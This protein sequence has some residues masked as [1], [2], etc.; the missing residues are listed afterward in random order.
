MNNY[1]NHP[2]DRRT[3]GKFIDELFEPEA[4]PLRA[5]LFT[6]GGTIIGFIVLKMAAAKIQTETLLPLYCIVSIA[7]L[8]GV[9]IYTYPLEKLKT[10]V[11]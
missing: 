5:V 3:E 7:I 1:C 9:F 10:V 6:L 11:T 8:P 2:K 4:A